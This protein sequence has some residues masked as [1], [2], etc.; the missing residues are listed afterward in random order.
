MKSIIEVAEKA[1]SLSL[2]LSRGYRFLFHLK[3][4]I[5]LRTIPKSRTNYFRMLLTNYFCNYYSYIEQGECGFARVSYDEMHN[6]IFP[7]NREEIVS[8]ESRYQS[9]CLKRASLLK[10]KYCDFMYD[11]GSRLDRV[12]MLMPRKMIG[13]YRN[14]FDALLSFYHYGWKARSENTGDCPDFKDMRK[15]LLSNYIASYRQMKRLFG[16][17]NGGRRYLLSYE[18]LFLQTHASLTGVIRFLGLPVYPG[19]LRLA[20]KA[21]S[22]QAVRKE[23]RK[24]GQAIHSPKK[25]LRG[26]FI[27]SARVGQ[28]AEKMDIDDF[29]YIVTRLSENGIDYRAFRLTE[30]NTIPP[31]F[32]EVIFDPPHDESLA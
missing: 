28:W 6:K 18:N 8:G 17:A 12:P 22:I 24:A 13:L 7:N 20:I 10:G 27:R 26:S 29:C 21:S 9:P 11:H 32:S 3:R 19:L 23:E 16:S 4:S 30:D 15:T 31:R 25:G 5:V 14:P 2:S 1:L